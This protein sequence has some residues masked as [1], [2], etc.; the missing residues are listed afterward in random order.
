MPCLTLEGDLA[1]D[2]PV[3]DEL[4]GCI[5]SRSRLSTRITD[6]GCGHRVGHVGADTLDLRWGDPIQKRRVIL[7][8]SDHALDV[9]GHLLRGNFVVTNEVLMGN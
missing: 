9:E 8:I 1:S 7:L 3:V 2:H 6:G 4:R 5:L